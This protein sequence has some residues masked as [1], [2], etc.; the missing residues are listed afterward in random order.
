MALISPSVGKLSDRIE[1]RVLSSIGMAISALGLLFLYFITFETSIIRLVIILVMLGIGFAMF[2]S[3]N[4]NAVMSSVEK[5]QLGVASGSL[6]TMRLIGQMFSMGIA[7]MLFAVFI[8][9]AEI[10]PSNLSRLLS[11][12]KIAFAIFAVLCFTG[13]FAS[14]ARGKVR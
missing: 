2:S 1:P 9:K 14:L 3:P 7:T 4:T 10:N 5:K 6:G 8:G 13:I 11:A 12:I